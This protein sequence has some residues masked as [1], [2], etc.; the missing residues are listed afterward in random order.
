MVRIHT[1]PIN[2]MYQIYM[3]GDMKN[4]YEIIIGPV[5]IGIGGSSPTFGDICK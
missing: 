5:A 4:Q 1:I 3:F 2:F